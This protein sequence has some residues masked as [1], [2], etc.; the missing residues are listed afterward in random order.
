MDPIAC[1][2]RQ[3]FAD[4]ESFW[5]AGSGRVARMVA[6]DEERGELVKALR[7]A[8]LSPENRWPL[9][10]FEAPF[11]ETHSYF[12]GLCDRIVRD[13]ELVREGAAQ[14][15]VML[16]PLAEDARLK[17][18]DGLDPLG[19]AAVYIER[20]AALLGERLDGVHIALVPAQ[21][22]AMTVWKKSIAMLAEAPL[23]AK[24]RVAVADPPAGPLEPVLGAQG[25][26]FAIDQAKLMAY[27]KKLA[28]GAR[29]LPQDRSHDAP[30]TRRS[31]GFLLLDAAEHARQGNTT[32]AAELYQRALVVCQAEELVIEEAG[33]RMALAGTFLAAGDGPAALKQ[34]HKAAELGESQGSLSIVCQ[35]H[36]GAGGVCLTFTRYEPAGK[37]YELAAEAAERGKI[38]L[39]RIEALRMAG[40]CHML[41]GA[42]EDALLAWVE[43]FNAGIAMDRQAR[44]V[45]TLEEAA[46]EL[47]ALL[48]DVGLSQH[49]ADVAAYLQRLS[50]ERTTTSD[51]PMTRPVLHD[52]A[53]RQQFC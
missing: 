22:G 14:E 5:Q 32:A 3:F 43:A 46:V 44:Q 27:T 4:M 23:S 26:R 41:R 42:K 13:Y 29:G 8:E 36:L 10:L 37:L 25:A 50:A 53:Q 17:S 45:S 15:G 39:L 40:T 6:S 35:A 7:V 28:Q 33:V 20:V 16:A 38:P 1:A 12:R 19:F 34:Y 31:L 47:R 51:F 21:V 24:V 30:A 48:A 18:A 11:M 9:V 2:A 52:R 49:A